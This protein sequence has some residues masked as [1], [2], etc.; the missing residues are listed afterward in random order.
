[1]NAEPLLQ[2]INPLLDW[3]RQR[4][5]KSDLAADDLQFNLLETIR[6]EE[7][8][9]SKEP[10]PV[11]FYRILRT[12]PHNHPLGERPLPGQKATPLIPDLPEEPSPED[13][14]NL[15]TFLLPLLPDL[16][17]L[18]AK[19]LQHVDFDGGTLDTLFPPGQPRPK[20]LQNHLQR[21]RRR[22][23]NSIELACRVCTTHRVLHCPC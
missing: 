1:M 14:A 6:G 3:A 2:H 16:P 15:V 11:W 12:C 9:N 10:S 5:G 20:N 4:S 8:F 17:P 7:L 21:A 18:D 13:L 19:L 23:R 22:L